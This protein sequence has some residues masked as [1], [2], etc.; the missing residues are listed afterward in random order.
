MHF[1]RSCTWCAYA[2]SHRN[3]NHCRKTPCRFKV[4]RFASYLSVN[5][6]TADKWNDRGVASRVRKNVRGRCHSP[7]CSRRKC[8][9]CS[10]TSRCSH[11]AP[12]GKS[13][14]VYDF[15]NWLNFSIFYNTWN[16]NTDYRFENNWLVSGQTE[17]FYLAE[18]NYL[19]SLNFNFWTESQSITS[20]C[21][22]PLLSPHVDQV[23]IEFLNK[24]V[25]VANNIGKRLL[26]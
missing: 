19:K 7:R 16:S 13:K 8:V 1:C 26:K 6:N 21:K 2:L 11:S 3:G 18:P 20:F 14:F 24:N 22:L 4:N 17:N 10:R 9:I 5:C 15:I 12:W 25:R 23:T